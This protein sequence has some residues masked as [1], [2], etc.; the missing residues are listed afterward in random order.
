MLKVVL[1]S[2][3]FIILAELAL[4]T[5]LFL[6]Q[7]VFSTHALFGTLTLYYECGLVVRVLDSRSDVRGF[8]PYYGRYFFFLFLWCQICFFFLKLQYSC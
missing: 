3:F 4:R 7:R 1:T 2:L 8:D 6:G 5:I